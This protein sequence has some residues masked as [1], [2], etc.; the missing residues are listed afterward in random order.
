MKLSLMIPTFQGSAE[1]QRTLTSVLAQQYRPL[2]VLVYDESSRR[3][4]RSWSA[5]WDRSTRHR[6]AL[7][8]VGREQWPRA[9]VARRAPRDHRRLV[10]FRLVRRRAEAPLRHAMMSAAERGNAAGHKIVT[11]SGD[12]EVDGVSPVLR[13]G[14]GHG[15]AG[16]V[17]GRDLPSPLPDLPDLLR[18]RDHGGARRCSTATSRSRIRADTTTNAIRTATTS[19]SSPSSQQRAGAPSSS[20]TAW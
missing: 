5:S 3:H 16:R 11:C 6:D 7:H 2:E 8:H 19:A 10:L 1:I 13:T 12:V 18:L 15:H 17:F 9:R 4:A 14:R 20:A